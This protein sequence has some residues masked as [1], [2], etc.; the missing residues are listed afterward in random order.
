VTF[1]VGFGGRLATGDVVAVSFATT[2][3]GV[4]NSN[5]RRAADAAE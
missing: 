2:R 1:S 3:S 5:A 4:A